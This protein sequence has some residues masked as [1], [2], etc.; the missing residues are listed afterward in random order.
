MEQWRTVAGFEGRYQV[1]NLGRVYSG[2]GYGEAYNAA[3]RIL[4]GLAYD[5]L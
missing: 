4:K 3:V 5:H 2:K 1:S